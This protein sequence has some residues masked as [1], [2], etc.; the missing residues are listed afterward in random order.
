MKSLFDIDLIGNVAKFSKVI[1][2]SNIIKII[3]AKLALD[4]AVII[5]YI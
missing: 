4:Y 2:N 1:I 5:A 3:L